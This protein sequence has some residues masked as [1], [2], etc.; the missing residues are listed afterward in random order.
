M[1]FHYLMVEP[2]RSKQQI[3]THVAGS[4]RYSCALNAAGPEPSGHARCGLV[5]AEEVG[6]RS[7][8]A[9]VQV[10]GVLKQA[11]QPWQHKTN[12]RHD[13][14]PYTRCHAR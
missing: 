3:E 7:C 4:L 5:A 9:H 1:P 6:P 2:R 14:V 10:F 12:T 8:D 11:P 13:Y